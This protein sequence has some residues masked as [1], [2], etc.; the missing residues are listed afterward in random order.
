[1]PP[2]SVH[3]LGGILMSKYYYET[4]LKIIIE[5]E[6]RYGRKYLC[7]NYDLKDSAI[8]NWIRLYKMYGEEVLNKSMSKTN[9]TGEFKLS[10]LQYRRNH[11]LSYKETV[12]HFNIKNP[13]TSANWNRKYKEEGFESLCG[14]VGRLKN[15]GGSDMPKGT[16]EPKKLDKSEREELIELRERNQYLEAE[17][18]YLKKLDACSRRK[19]FK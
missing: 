10:V 4:K 7:D 19:D 17:L 9:Y 14:P 1:M 16:N 8:E 6:Q 5:N 2:K 3:G 12:E 18:L 11:K 15:N 13:Y